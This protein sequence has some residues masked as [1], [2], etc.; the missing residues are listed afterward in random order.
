MDRGQV[1]LSDLP[2]QG[3]LAQSEVLSFDD[4]AACLAIGG[5]EAGV[6]LG[7]IVETIENASPALEQ[8]VSIFHTVQPL[9]EEAIPHR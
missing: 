7:K 4:S 8:A 2:A 9:Y 1:G 3:W 5:L 6:S